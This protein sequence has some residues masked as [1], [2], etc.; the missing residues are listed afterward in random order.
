MPSA[1]VVDRKDVKA[2]SL[3]YAVRDDPC[4]EGLIYDSFVVKS[5]MS[6]WSEKAALK[7][8]RG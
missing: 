5:T 2:R 8:R 4:S 7:A 3:K 1:A 6:W